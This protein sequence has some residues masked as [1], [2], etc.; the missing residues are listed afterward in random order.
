[1]WRHLKYAS[2]FVGLSCLVL[3]LVAAGTGGVPLFNAFLQT[4]MNGGDAHGPHSIT[5]L[6]V[7]AVSNLNA[8]NIN[9]YTITAQ[10]SLTL[11]GAS[12]TTWPTGSITNATVVNGINGPLTIHGSAITTNSP[13]DYL[14]T[15]G[16]GAATNATLVNGVA[17]PLTIH[18]PG[19]TTNSPGDYSFNGGGVDTNAI[20]SQVTNLGVASSNYTSISTA[21]VGL[22]LTNDINAHGTGICILAEGSG[23]L[24]NGKSTVSTSYAYPPNGTNGIFVQYYQ[25]SPPNGTN[26]VLSIANITN[27]VSFDVRSGPGDTNGFFWMVTGPHL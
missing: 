6:N 7:V 22:N 25:G 17:G 18:G 1:M 19:I 13:S 26:A 16:G 11:N 21:T 20:L 14:F 15:G 23:V 3:L 8:Q 4:D 2:L 10:N 9:G 24:V 27:G 12:I 5:N